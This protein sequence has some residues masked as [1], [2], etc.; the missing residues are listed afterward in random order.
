MTVMAL[1]ARGAVDT[2]YGGT[3]HFTSSDPAAT[4]PPDYTFTA[5]DKGVHTFDGVTLR[6]AGVRVITASDSRITG[7]TPVIVNPAA[8]AAFYINV[9]DTVT[10][11]ASFDMTVYAFDR[12]GNLPPMRHVADAR[13]NEG[14]DHRQWNESDE[15]GRGEQENR[16]ENSI[17]DARYRGLRTEVRIFRCVGRDS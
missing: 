1:T 15:R 4:L 6:S 16:A 13:K 5:A 2:Q 17:Q 12:F 8:A 14:R 10:A 3:I 11:G 7:I 9:P